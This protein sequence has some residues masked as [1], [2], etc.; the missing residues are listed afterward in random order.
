MDLDTGDK[1]RF[2]R[3]RTAASGWALRSS[4]GWDWRA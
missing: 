1:V 3:A 4:G 2:K